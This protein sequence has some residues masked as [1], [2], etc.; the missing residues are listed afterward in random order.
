VL[1]ETISR[2]L[3]T[4]NIT[5]AE[6]ICAQFNY[7]NLDLQLAKTALLYAEGTISVQSFPHGIEQIETVKW[8]F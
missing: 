1:N 8:P 5:K 4:G 3:A 7:E 2:L 6:A